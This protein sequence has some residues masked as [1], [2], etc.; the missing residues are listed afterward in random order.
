MNARGLCSPKLIAICLSS[1]TGVQVHAQ[2]Q[3]ASTFDTISA[4]PKV[5]HLEVFLPYADSIQIG[6]NLGLRPLEE[7]KGIVFAQL[8]PETNPGSDFIL[9]A[10]GSTLN[11]AFRLHGNAPPYT[12]EF[13]GSLSLAAQPKTSQ[14]KIEFPIGRLTRARLFDTFDVQGFYGN[15]QQKRP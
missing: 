4:D 7:N 11:I 5:L 3:S 8:S 2:T 12:V 15:P 10:N 9:R 6:P 1:F 14:Q 13:E